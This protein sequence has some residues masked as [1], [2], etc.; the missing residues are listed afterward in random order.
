[1]QF[2]NLARGTL[3]DMN[4]FQSLKSFT[5]EWTYVKELHKLQE[6]DGSNMAIKS[7]AVPTVWKQMQG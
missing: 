4:V 6:S 2:L 5:D 1:M 7:K 3:W